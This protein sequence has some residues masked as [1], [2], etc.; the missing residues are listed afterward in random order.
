M[1]AKRFACYPLVSH[2]EYVK[3]ALLRLE[4]RDRQTVGQQTDTLRLQ[5]DS[6][7][8]KSC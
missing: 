8:V 2:V 7:S 3:R 5:L 4:K 6:V 1:Y